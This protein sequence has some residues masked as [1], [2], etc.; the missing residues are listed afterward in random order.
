MGGIGK[1]TLA[2][3]VYK[4]ERVKK[5]FDLQAWVC[6][7]DEFDV[8]RV[9]KTILEE[10][11]SSTNADSKNLNRLQITLQE[12]LMGKKLLL[13]LDDVWDENYVDWEV[14]SS[15]FKYGERGSTIIVTTRN[16]GVASVMR[17]VPTHHLN[18]LLEEDCWSLFA[19]HS[20]LDGNSNARSELDVIGRQIVKKCEGLPLALKTI[21]GLL[22]SKLDVDEWE[23]I[24]KSELWDSPIDKTNILPS[25]RL[26]YK[27][28]PSHLKRCFGY[29][30]IFPKGYAFKKDLLVLL[31]MAEG[32]LQLPINRTM[33]E[34][35]EDYFHDLVSRSLF[36]Q[37][38][39]NKSAF[40]MHD[41]VNELAN[42]VSGQFSFRLEG[43]S[44]D[45]IVNKTRHLSYF[46][47]RF[48]NFKKFETLNKVKQLRTFLPFEFSIMDNNLTK[49][50]PHDLLPKLRYLRVLSLS[51]YENVTYLPDS[52]GKIKQ[53]RYL[54]LSFTAVKRLPDSICELINLQ[55]LNLSCCNN[56]VRLPRDMRKLINLRHLDITR[57]DI[58]EMPIQLGRLKCL[59]T[60]TTF[61]ISKTSGS[62]IGELGK[63][64]NLRGKLAI[65]NLQNVVSSSDAL[66]AGLKDKK[67][68]KELVLEWKASTKILESQR[69]ILD[70]VQPHSNLKSLTIKY[71]SG[72]SFPDWVGHDSFSNIVSLHLYDCKYCCSL[73]PLGQLPSLQ[74]LSVIKFDEVVTV[75][76]EF[77]GN[78]FFSIKPFG[79]LK[80]LRFEQMLKWKE[81]FSFDAE[82]EGEAFP[83][84]QELYIYDCP[85]LTKS[86]PI[87]LPLAKLEIRECPLLM[88]SLSGA[89]AICQLNLTFCNE[90]LLKELP[91]GIRV[92][93]VGGFEALDSLAMQMESSCSLQEL[94]I[95]NCS[96]L[97]SLSMVDL[98]STLKSLSIR[99]C[100]KLE[101][102]MH[103]I[104]SSLKK[105]HLENSYDSLR[106]FPLDLFPN[107]SDIHISRCGN[108]ESLTISKQHELDLKILHMRIIDCPYFV[109]FPERGLRASKLTLL[110]VWNCG[111]LRSLPDKMHVLLPSLEE[112][113]IVHCTEVESFP[114]GGLPSNLKSISIIDCDNLVAGRMGWGLQ[115]LPF[116]KK[117]FICGE[118]GEVESF[119]EVGLLPTNLT[120][121]QIMNFPNMKS[122]DKKG[123]QH[124]ASL[125]E[126]R[127][128]NCHILKYM[129][130]EGLPASVSVLLI[131]NCPLVKKQCHRKKGKEWRKI[132]HVHLIMIDDELIE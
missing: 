9:T 4:D 8:F 103:Q 118:K 5:H 79:A 17:T 123:L 31:W 77:Y 80:V 73:P 71:Y 116:L 46:R 126:L 129:P 15:P 105:L 22:R 62:C 7:S 44:F 43:D 86:L 28:L 61:I 72:R 50:V 38:C 42:F 16:D 66:D 20:C 101:L 108:L 10:V 14:L 54:D 55:T 110:W 90:Y 81:W 92:L 41:L 94:E 84:L 33:E 69:T 132:S 83:H 70:S 76:L 119:P 48:D 113:H 112:L 102:P 120:V 99:N 26:S 97:V 95:S 68:I 11:G 67:H 65:L 59:Q 124:L 32:F 130:E 64:T 49:K 93:K 127:I 29:C 111:Q 24:L 37:S 27:Y 114:E 12:K 56:L 75:G 115:K 47:T 18:K 100:Q 57:T 91:T 21:G 2:Q 39:D 87:Q 109:S 36:Q 45:R 96:S 13:V 6:V 40:V 53:L 88:V 30:S 104:F 74:D 23:K 131:S 63:L 89:P 58:M 19:K 25:L 82:S 98:P 85:K 128:Y 125:K 121:L 35:G 1:T 107:L 117:L 106:S 3:L 60:L 34:V 51:H 122:L 52:I 78:G